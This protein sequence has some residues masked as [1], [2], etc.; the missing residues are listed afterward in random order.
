M[1]MNQILITTLSDFKLTYSGR[2]DYVNEGG[3]RYV[4]YSYIIDEHPEDFCDIDIIKY[5][6]KLMRLNNNFYTISNILYGHVHYLDKEG[7]EISSPRLQVVF[8]NKRT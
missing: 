8:L 6:S 4:S 3:K 2:F 1:K 5:K 7:N